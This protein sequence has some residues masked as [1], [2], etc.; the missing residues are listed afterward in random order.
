M[1]KIN[2]GVKFKNADLIQLAG[3]KLLKR[4]KPALATV[5]N[6]FFAFWRTA[7]AYK[8]SLVAISWHE[9]EY[10]VVDQT[11]DGNISLD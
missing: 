5:L 10:E 3:R 7:M 8:T 9:G 4:L 2:Y 1:N 6:R 11:S